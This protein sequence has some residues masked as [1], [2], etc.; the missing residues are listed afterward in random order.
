MRKGYATV[1]GFATRG[2]K[3]CILALGIF[4]LLISFT[5]ADV[6]DEDS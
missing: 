4:L 2:G 1:M 5:N 3:Y 6:A